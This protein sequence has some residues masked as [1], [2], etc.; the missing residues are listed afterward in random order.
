[1]ISEHRT[2][3]EI[4]KSSSNESNTQVKVIINSKLK[5]ISL[6]TSCDL[7]TALK[8]MLIKL[9]DLNPLPTGLFMS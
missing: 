7:K 1:M 8:N 9:R 6:L 4:Q 5:K 2:E 3:E